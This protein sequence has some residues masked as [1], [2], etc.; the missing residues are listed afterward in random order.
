MG[1]GERAAAQ[2]KN[3]HSGPPAGGVVVSNDR[4]L[5]PRDAADELGVSVHSIYRAID[6]GRLTAYRFTKRGLSISA[7]GLET[8][9]ERSRVR[10]G[11][12]RMVGGPQVPD[13]IETAKRMTRR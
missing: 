2:F 7:A 8:F 5:S 3:A 10:R 9:K 11:P 1:H 13:L 12:R 6:A 4:W